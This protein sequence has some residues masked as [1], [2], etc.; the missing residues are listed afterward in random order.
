MQDYPLKKNNLNKMTVLQLGVVFHTNKDHAI[1]Q[2]VGVHFNVETEKVI[3]F[4]RSV[5]PL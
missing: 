5:K 1:F 2:N 3:E 4:P